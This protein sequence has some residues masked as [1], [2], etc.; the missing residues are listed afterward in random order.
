[1]NNT[2]K[3]TIGKHMMPL[4]DI[5]N[6]IMRGDKPEEA[7]G[8]F[9][10]YAP[11]SDVARL[12]Y[13]G[14][15]A[16]QHR[17]QESAG[18]CVSNGDQ[19]ACYAKMG[20]VNQVFNEQI[21]GILRGYMAT[22]H[23]RYSTTGS[24]VLANAQ[25]ILVEE[26][27]DL[28][29]MGKRRKK[30]TSL[31]V[32]HNGN[33]VNTGDLR[34][35]C[36][37]LGL[38][39]TTTS[40]S[41]IM[42]RLLHHEYSKHENLTEAIKTMLPQFKGAFAMTIQ[43]P[44]EIVAVRDVPGI[45]PMVAGYLGDNNDP[46]GWVV[47]SETCALDIIG[48]SH[49]FDVTPGSAVVLNETGISQ[50]RWRNGEETEKLCAFEY[51]YFARP[52]SYFRGKSIHAIRQRMGE[53]M[54]R[55]APADADI[56]VSVPDSGTPHAIGFA[57]AS[58]IPYTE[59]LIKNRYVGRTFIDPRERLRAL[60]VRMKLNPLEEVLRGQR[61]VL[62]D[63]S[64][65]RGTTSKKII[66]LLR[67]A[68]VTEVHFRVASPPVLNPCFYGIDTANQEELIASQY[69]NGG[70]DWSALAERLGADSLAYLSIE[71]M[72]EA[73]GHAENE[74]CLAC[75]NGS[76]PIPISSQTKLALNKYIL[77]PDKERESGNGEVLTSDEE[78]SA[79]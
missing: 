26:S 14:L 15:F 79:L 45:R 24:S 21:L 53:I 6:E 25:P 78:L 38:T 59:G 16:L 73:F 43:T 13:F 50:F 41:E 7:C 5:P 58:G 19:M 42:A 55:E 76:Y 31:A 36:T 61:V 29:V 71:G 62:V 39:L 65:V 72:L 54:A 63:D 69:N 35:Q 60:G 70:N 11:H 44:N 40:D 52:D 2:G 47:A 10:V 56:I 68:G 20:L 37:D 48:A 18:I 22:G 74:L 75:L 49:A 17:G 23:T 64:I 33:L 77:E 27:R 12:T 4:T 8:I 67:D 57:R 9:G 66:Q 30:T 28:S 46:D 3:I 34:K 1:V 51:I 32:A